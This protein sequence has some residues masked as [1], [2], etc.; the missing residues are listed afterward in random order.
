MSHANDPDIMNRLRRAQGHLASVVQMVVEGRDG[1]AISQQM[2]AVI[3]ALEKTKQMLIVD[4]IDHHLEE[5]TGPL[6]SDTRQKIA[7]LREIAKYL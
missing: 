7:D 1:L 3:K 6:S 4:Y 5:M 2:Q